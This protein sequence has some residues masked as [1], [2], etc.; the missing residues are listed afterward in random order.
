MTINN[1][2]YTFMRMAIQLAQSQAGKP[3]GRPF[4]AVITMGGKILARGFNRTMI[5]RD[6]TAHAEIVAIRRACK[7]TAITDLEQCVIYASCQPCPMCLSAI[8][9][10]GIRTIYFGCSSA[11]A[12]QVGFGDKLFIRRGVCEGARRTDYTPSVAGWGSVRGAG[13]MEATRRPCIVSQFHETRSDAPRIRR[14]D[15]E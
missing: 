1:Q 9:W 4:G 6:P 15:D 5:D 14:A 13:G 2:H 7:K 3:N 8:Y 12:E 11:K 10:S